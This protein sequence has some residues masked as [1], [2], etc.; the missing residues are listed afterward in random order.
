MFSKTDVFN[1]FI[2]NIGQFVFWKDRSSVYLGCNANFARSAGYAHPEE[3]VGKTDYDMPWSAEEAEFFRKID[4]EVMATGVSKLNFE[5]PQTMSDGSTRWLSTSK[6]PLRGKDNEVE[7]ILGWYIDITPYKSMQ[8]QIDQK[9]EALLQ[10]SQQLSQSNSKIEQANRDM[11]LF[12]YAVSHDLRAPISNIVGF[13]D[14]ILNKYGSSLDPAITSK[15]DRVLGSGRRMNNLVQNILTYARTGLEKQESEKVNIKKLINSKLP[16]LD[17]HLVNPN[18]K[19]TVDIPD[20]SV[21]CYPEMLGLVFYNLIANGLKY[22]ESP[23]PVVHC[24]METHNTHY[25]FSVRDNGMGISPENAEKIFMPF[26]R[27][28]STE[29]RGSGLGLSICKRITELHLGQI[30]LEQVDTEG[31]DFRFSISRQL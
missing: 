19:I 11:E 16:A 10:Y 28:H 4:N 9:N 25:V 5:E 18:T 22:N 13:T 15:L 1:S 3:I 31:S 24:T 12:T 14:L 7:G 6:V 8:I 30:W 20:V 17:Q 26:K 21:P 23:M 2:D 29:L 27:F